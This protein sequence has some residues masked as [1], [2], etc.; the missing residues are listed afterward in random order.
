M[1]DCCPRQQQSAG[2][3]V[4]ERACSLQHSTRHNGHLYERSVEEIITKFKPAVRY[5]HACCCPCN[6]IEWCWT[7][8]LSH[9]VHHMT[10]TSRTKGEQKLKYRWQ[11]YCAC[12][13]CSKK[14][15]E[16][17]HGVAVDMSCLS[18][19][20]WFFRSGQV[21]EAFLLPKASPPPSP[22]IVFFSGAARL[23]W[24]HLLKPSSP[25]T[26]SRI[27]YYS[28]FLVTQRK[29]I[30]GWQ[31]IKTKYAATLSLAYLCTHYPKQVNS[32]DFR[33]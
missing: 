5:T 17:G 4:C 3:D 26:N 19:F 7:I 24:Y 6:K 22:E 2:R 23:I 27:G 20:M 16:A 1:E 31:N 18:Y 12:Y 21:S 15:H 25:V 30:L 8:G 29:L 9:T 13:H 14:E 10:Y 28:S 33:I 11:Y 32:S